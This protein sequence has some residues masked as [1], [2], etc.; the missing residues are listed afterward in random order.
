MLLFEK[1]QTSTPTR[2]ENYPN[3]EDSSLPR[4]GDGLSDGRDYG[5]AA[6]DQ[7][8]AAHRRVHEILLQAITVCGN[9]SQVEWGKETHQT[10]GTEPP[11][12][13]GFFHKRGGNPTCMSMTSMVVSLHWAAAA[14]DRCDLKWLVGIL[15]IM[16]ATPPP[17]SQRFLR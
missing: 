10:R 1:S 12:I 4:H 15:G 14:M 17:E 6:S 13:R 7:Q 2:K 8:R 16:A 3:N 5:L 11:K 9:N